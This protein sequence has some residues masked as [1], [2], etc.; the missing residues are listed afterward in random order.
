MKVLN[1]E[2]CHYKESLQDLFPLDTGLVGLGNAKLSWR[3]HA[4]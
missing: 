1:G 4:R 3:A 2:V